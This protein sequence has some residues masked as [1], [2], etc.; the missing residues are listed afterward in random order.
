VHVMNLNTV[1][2]D[3]VHQWDHGFLPNGVRLQQRIVDD[4]D[5]FT[6]T[7]DAK[8]NNLLHT[9]CVDLEAE[10]SVLLQNS[11]RSFSSPSV[12]ASTCCNQCGNEFGRM[13][14]TSLLQGIL[15]CVY[16]YVVGNRSPRLPI[17]MGSPSQGSGHARGHVGPVGRVRLVG[18]VYACIN[19]CYILRKQK[20][21]TWWGRVGMYEGG[22]ASCS[23]VG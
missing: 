10:A 17:D 15:M 13:T 20:V 18:H 12:L 2:R 8:R 23:L 6:H 19:M 9:F 3:Y 11:E 1:C 4:M 14:P 21:C 16:I 7:V 5:D 22:S